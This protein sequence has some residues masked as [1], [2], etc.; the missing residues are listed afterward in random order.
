MFVINNLMFII[1]YYMFLVIHEWID[2]SSSISRSSLHLPPIV[3]LN[4]S[5]RLFQTI[6]T[7]VLVI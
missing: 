5:H 4:A 7:T 3:A 1:K 6:R 2:S